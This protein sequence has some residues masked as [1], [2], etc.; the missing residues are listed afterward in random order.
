MEDIGSLEYTMTTGFDI[1][2]PAVGYV[3]EAYVNGAGS[4]PYEY[5]YDVAGGLAARTSWQGRH[6]ANV[7]AGDLYAADVIPAGSSALL[8]NGGVC[9]VAPGIAI[10]ETIL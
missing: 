3:W 2:D 4:T 8:A 7:P 5:H 6:V 9:G 1:D 10:D